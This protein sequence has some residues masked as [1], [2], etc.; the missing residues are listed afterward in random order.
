MKQYVGL[1]VSLEQTAVCIVDEHGKALWRGKCAST[2]EAIAAVVKARAPH[3]VRIGLESG[4]LSTWHWHELKKHGLPVICLDAR[5]AKAALSLQVNKT[6]PNDALGLAQIVRTGWYREV[7]VKSLDSQVIRSFLSSRARLVEVRV[8]LINQI[9][10]MLKPFGLVAG[11]GGRQ[12]FVD[13]VRELVADGPLKDAVEALLTALQEVSRQIG[14]LSRRLM[15]LARQNQAARRLMTAPG[16]GSLVALA[17]ISVIDAPERFSKSSSVGAYLGLTP[18]RYQSGEV[19]RSGRISKCGDPLLR[20][21][22]FEA[23]GIILNRVSRWS[24]IKAWGT[25][26]ARKVGGKKAMVAVAR[27]LSVI[28][29]RMWHDGTDF[30]WSNK[31]GLPA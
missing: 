3:V 12:P 10:G 24:S 6:D 23:A 13:R 29:H 16:V 27:K 31:E 1:D 11:K 17:Y 14:I 18:R 15:A 5:H 4:P 9:R 2:P 22:L 20:T 21:Y 8:D 19:D 28:L 25:R 26:L 30:R 7:T